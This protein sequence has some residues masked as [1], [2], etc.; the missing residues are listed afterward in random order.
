MEE[1]KNKLNGSYYTPRTLAKFLIQKSLTYV[2]NGNINVLEPSCGDGV[3]LNELLCNKNFLS[4]KKSFI[5]T[6]EKDN[7][8]LEK[9]KRYK[10]EFTQNQIKTSY[11]SMDFL[12]FVPKHNK[13]YDLIIGNPPYINKKFLTNKQ[14]ESSKEI[15]RG[16]NLEVST[17]YNIWIPFVVG[18][19]EL[20]SK[21]GVLCLVLPAELLQVKYAEPIRRYLFQ[22]FN[23]FHI[24][25]FDNRIF[26]GI[27][28]DVVIFFGVKSSN[29]KRIVHQL[30]STED[31]LEIIE[32][33][34]L[35]PKEYLNK[36]LWYLLTQ[37]EIEL[38]TRMK[39]RF[40]TMD[41]Y[42]T[43][44]AGIVTGNNNY[45]ILN[46]EEVEK[47]NL[48]DWVKPILKKSAFI[49]E[50]LT[51]SK[52]D[53]NKLLETNSP[54][55]LLDLNSLDSTEMPL[56]IKKYLIKGESQ[57]VNNGFKCKQR[58]EWYK[59]PSIWSSEGI[60]F[61][62]IH[63]F[64]K[65]LKNTMNVCITDTGYRIRMNKGFNIDSLI[66]SFYNSLTMLL[67]ELEGRYYGGGVLEITP[68]EFKSIA[69]PYFEVSDEQINVLQNL[70]SANK[71]FEEVLLYTDEI[72]LDQ[73][74]NIG[75]DDI[76]KLRSIRAKLVN[77]RVN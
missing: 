8:E 72:I 14:K 39:S 11:N 18:C 34:I 41:K 76:N 58:I 36:W 62:R 71:P 13:K 17:I 49:K 64:P 52:N 19:A 12:D 47:N 7:L 59:I 2:K 28:Q 63:L 73:C 30:V 50:S 25:S 16:I 22:E 29:N 4:R 35:N 69:L 51:F 60:F 24:M 23:E 75:Q 68:N 3:F 67:L 10:K 53:F 40:Y 65:L 20:L 77:F 31:K 44:T 55:F 32:Q 21:N 26:E 9:A 45:F 74:E 38:L 33:N 46:K 15:L 37:D 56:E 1:N 66:F 54:C 61:K 5:C 43:S 27:E 48:T 42:C 57:G 6:V 70:I